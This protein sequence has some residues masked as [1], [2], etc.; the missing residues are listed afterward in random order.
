MRLSV[1]GKL[2]WTH[3]ETLTFHE[4]NKLIWQSLLMDYPTNFTFFL[5]VFF[6]TVFLFVFSFFLTIVRCPAAPSQYHFP[7][8][9]RPPLRFSL[10]FCRFGTRFKIPCTSKNCIAAWKLIF[11]L[12]TPKTGENQRRLLCLY[13]YA[14]WEWFR[15]ICLT[16][17]QH[18]LI[19]LIIAPNHNRYTHTH[20]QPKRTAKTPKWKTEQQK[21]DSW[22]I[23]M[24]QCTPNIVSHTFVNWLASIYHW[25]AFFMLWNEEKEAN[26]I[27]VW[28]CAQTNKEKS[29]PVLIVFINLLNITINMVLPR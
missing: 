2:I 27:G 29:R 6:S 21:N 10:P 22:E 16:R 24:A 15:L 23:G 1:R 3:C 13:E 28:W 26:F 18:Y 9:F 25:R 12:R 14:I 19:M 17:S 20:N 8:F 11:P 5:I 4:L 7:Y